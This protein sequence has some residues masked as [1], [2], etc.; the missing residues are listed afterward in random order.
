VEEDFVISAFTSREIRITLIIIIIIIIQGVVELNSV[1]FVG[2]LSIATTQ[3]STL[4]F[5][6]VFKARY[7]R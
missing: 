3:N 7:P 6:K 4:C 5:G 1:T 2:T